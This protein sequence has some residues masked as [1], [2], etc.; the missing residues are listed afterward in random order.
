MKSETLKTEQLTLE[1]TEGTGLWLDLFVSYG[2]YG[3]NRSEAAERLLTRAI[4]DTATEHKIRPPKM[5]SA[6]R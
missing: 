1:I 3:A 2:L 6:K 4:L 5:P